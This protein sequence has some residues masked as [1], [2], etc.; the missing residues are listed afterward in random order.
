MHRCHDYHYSNTCT[1]VLRAHANTSDSLVHALLCA[2][3]EVLGLIFD[4]FVACR[5][6]ALMR[7]PLVGCS[8]ILEAKLL[9]VAYR[10]TGPSQARLSRWPL[11]E[12]GCMHEIVDG[13]L[14]S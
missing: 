11:H 10:S 8:Q 3:A 4:T 1:Q 5:Q 7:F 14:V 12:S 6:N 13:S 9:A 2:I